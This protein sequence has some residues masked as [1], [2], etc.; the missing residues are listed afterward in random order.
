M[1][2]ALSPAAR[3]A[4]DSVSG[5]PYDGGPP[6]NPALCVDSLTQPAQHLKTIIRATF[7]WATNIGGLNCRENT[8]NN[9]TVSIHGLGR[10]L[11][12]MM[13][14]GQIGGPNGLAVANW[15]VL[16]A[17]A[18]GIQLVI[19]D[20]MIWQPSLPRAQ[21]FQPYEG[22]NPHTDHVHLE[23]TEAGG[24]GA[25]VTGNVT[26]TSSSFEDLLLLVIAGGGLWFLRKHVK[27]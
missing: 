24:N 2:W 16:N 8:G 26:S 17:K 14:A 25:L 18:L 6:W 7:P 10:A 4:S 12:V 20:R 21:R 22:S 13:P 15:A 23:V 19:W 3:A 1:T 5:I 9:A 11:D 27:R